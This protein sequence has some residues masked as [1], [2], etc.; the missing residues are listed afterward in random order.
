MSAIGDPLAPSIA[1]NTADQASIVSGGTRGKG[2]RGAKGK[3]KGKGKGKQAFGGK[4]GGKAGKH[5]YVSR[6]AR[7][8]LH[9]P[10]GR[11]H[12]RLKEG[13][14]R[15]QRC[16]GSAAIYCAALLEYLTAELLELA[17]H[18]AKDLDPECRRLKPRHLLLAIRGDDE[19]GKVVDATIA[20]GGVVPYLHD[21]LDKKKKK[22]AGGK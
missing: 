19:L 13:L 4:T 18:A 8:G 5:A 1:G 7:A 21:A 9:F 22:K 10:V 15:K 2:K 20:E 16:G 3:G 11:I 14:L 12:M 17:G 6:S